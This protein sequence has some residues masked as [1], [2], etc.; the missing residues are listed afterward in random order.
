MKFAARRSQIKLSYR[1]IIL[2][3]TVRSVERI[4]SFLKLIVIHVK[5]LCKLNQNQNLRTIGNILERI[6]DRLNGHSALG[7]DGN[8]HSNTR[9][10]SLDIFY[11]EKSLSC[12]FSMAV[13]KMKLILKTYY[14]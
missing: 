7:G 9:A 6:A 3:F 12:T 4:S 14:V 1:R 13:N 5:G 8:K 2:R 11:I 10:A